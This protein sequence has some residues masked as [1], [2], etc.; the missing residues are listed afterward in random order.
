MVD[1]DYTK[2]EARF[3]RYRIEYIRWMGQITVQVDC[4]Q[5]KADMGPKGPSSLKRKRGKRGSRAGKARARRQISL[6]PEGSGPPLKHSK[7]V[8]SFGLPI[9]YEKRHLR[10]VDHAYLFFSRWYEM[11]KQ[12][13]RKELVVELVAK[14]GRYGRTLVGVLPTLKRCQDMHKLGVDT[15]MR[16]RLARSQVDALRGNHPPDVYLLRKK[17]GVV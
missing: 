17:H 4:G 9:R 5:L 11:K 1:K 6:Q 3:R 15:L 14:N 7:S 2:I 10:L 13:D 8:G 16:G 12:I